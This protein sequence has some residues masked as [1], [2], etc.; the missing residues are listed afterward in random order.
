VIEEALEIMID[1]DPRRYLHLRIP[2]REALDR[3][4]ISI[5]GDSGRAEIPSDALGVQVPCQDTATCIAITIPRA[6]P[7]SASTVILEVPEI[8]HQARAPILRVDAGPYGL[9]TSAEAANTQIS[10]TLDDP[11]RRVFSMLDTS[12][13]GGVLLFP[14]NFE[15]HLSPGACADPPSSED[16]GWSPLPSTRGMIPAPF[17]A[18]ADPL[19]CLRLRPALPPGGS[20]VLAMS[21][22]ARAIVDTFQHVYT[23]PT[24]SAPLVYLPMYDLDLPS[25]MRCSD[26]EGLIDSSVMNAAVSVSANDPEHPPILRLDPQRISVNTAG[27]LCQQDDSR[28]FDPIA[29]A[30][31]IR[32][33]LDAKLPGRRA[34]VLAVYANNL[35]LELPVP[36]LQSFNTLR[37]SFPATSTSAQQLA[38]FAIAPTRA[39]VSLMPDQGV[40]FVGTE[41][42]AFGPIVAAGLGAVWPFRTVLHNDQTVVPLLAA[43][44]IAKYGLY[45][46]CSASAPISPI[47]SSSITQGILRPGPVGPA[48]TVP[49]PAQVLQPPVHF[50]PPSVQV[51]WQG[52][53]AL[54][55]RALPDQALIWTMEG[56]C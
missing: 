47:G 7:G 40:D 31:R 25:E 41:E 56:P 50:D 53:R 10:L 5:E 22:P 49:L 12:T 34:R 55:D 3:I 18:T 38:L 44:E 45:R 37:A 32:S 29:L 15:L 23:P 17:P 9:E 43:A 24:E 6:V 39:V 21:V 33:A 35:N 1:G 42:P 36:L 2:S 20:E 16:H 27:V 28:N 8:G 26:A 46:I 30:A 19:L 11:I 52:C 4:R 48:Y 54:C 51:R 13:P 14:R